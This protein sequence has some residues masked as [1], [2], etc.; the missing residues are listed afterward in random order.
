[1]EM[2]LQKLSHGPRMPISLDKVGRDSNASGL[3][4]E[5]RRGYALL[6]R[7]QAAGPPP[8]LSISEPTYS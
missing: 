8:E 2:G 6:P 3:V 4:W 5:T 1:M 7:E